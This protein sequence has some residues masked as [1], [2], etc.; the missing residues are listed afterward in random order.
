MKKAILLIPAILFC[1]IQSFSQGSNG[2]IGRWIFEGNANDVSGHGMN[3][4]EHN[5]TPTTGIN[6][7]PNTAYQF[8]GTSSYINIPY[9]SLMNT[10]IHS[11]CVLLK[12]TGFY[13]GNCQ[14]NAIIWRGRDV[15]PNFS[16]QLEMF[17]NAYDNS[18]AVYSPTHEVFAGWT[19]HTT[20]NTPQV[21]WYYTP[22]TELNSWY[23]V[24]LTYDGDSTRIYVNDVLK[25]TFYNT[26]TY[27]NTTDS[28]TFGWAES[29]FP[30]WLNA[31][32]DEIR[33]YNRVL[34]PAEVAMFGDSLGTG[35]ILPVKFYLDDNNNCTK[36]TNEIYNGLPLTV[37]VDSNGVPIDTI[38]ATGVLYYHARG[39]A[40]DVYSF[41]VVS[42]AANIYVSCPATG[43]LNDTLL[44]G[45]NPTKYVGFNCT[46]SA[47]FDLGVKLSTATDIR[48]QVLCLDVSNQYCSAQPATLKVNFSPKYVYGSASPAPTTVSGNSVT[49]NLGSLSYSNSPMNIHMT[50]NAPAGPLTAGDTTITK[51]YLDPS[52][53]DLNIYDNV[54]IDT[55]TIKAPLDPNEIAVKPEGCIP[56]N[57]A[58]TLT[59]TVQ[60]ENVGNDTAHNIYIM[61]TMPDN[62][63]IKSLRLISTSHFMTISKWYDD[64]Y[65]NIFKF[66]FP[67]ID[68]LDS[69][70]HD[71]CSGT[72]VF[73]VNTVTGLQNGAN[74]DNHA[75]IFF[76][77]NAV[78]MTNTVENTACFALD[79][80]RVNNEAH[81][82]LFPNPGSGQ[83]TITG[84]RVIKELAVYNVIGQEIFSGSYNTQKVQLN[85]KDVPT[86]LYFVKVN[87][88]EVRK[89]VKE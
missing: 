48:A 27:T 49:W 3:G 14:G 88:S 29:G 89:Y 69:S 36:E 18:D 61:D 17:D 2:L 34:S 10:Q 42:S 53:G 32:V 11:F 63:D 85:L 38:P 83:I 58:S 39:N 6:G 70:H 86:G 75:G 12:P 45:I 23:S 62:I 79:V 1:S 66:E 22:T 28:M 78:V 82:E 41:R 7:T 37:A 77:E 67:D 87:N 68:L 19:G 47:S 46:P 20:S 8:N 15:S 56:V 40:G 64:N 52:V 76:D 16:Y 30:Y 50:V 25:N 26:C 55:D 31:A 72:L 44:T 9:N 60:F 65:H 71:Q 80:P 73:K 35:K 33:F 59:Y 21:E 4:I 74:I 57:I 13:S 54:I 24:V 43:V 5:V 51:C 81:V 84:N